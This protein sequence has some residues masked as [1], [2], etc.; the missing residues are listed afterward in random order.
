M[1]EAEVEELHAPV[2][3]DE[4]VRRLQ[5]AVQDAAGVGVR[6]PLRH[7]F[8][9]PQR[10]V[11]GEGTL[12]DP[13]GQRLASEQFHHEIRARRA[14]PHVVDGHDGRMVELR[15]RL[16]LRLYPLLGNQV[17]GAPR[18]QG[19]EGY[20]SSELGIEG[21]VDRAETA[22]ADLAPD[23]V[24]ADN[25]P[26]LERLAPGRGGVLR[27]RLGQFLEEARDRPWLRGRRRVSRIVPYVALLLGHAISPPGILR[28]R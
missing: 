27:R 12:L 18:L 17:L 25:V 20:D 1:G 11:D 3:A 15:D 22:P 5:V 2:V 16:G 24:A 13:P 8:R 23:L 10:L 14:G 26:G 9:D 19:L 21:L 7:P 6:E 4:D 28:G